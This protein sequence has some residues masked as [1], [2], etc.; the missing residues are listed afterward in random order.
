MYA[1]SVLWFA[2]LDRPVAIYVVYNIYD[3][4][5]RKMKG[6]ACE[7]SPIKPGGHKRCALLQVQKTHDWSELLCRVHKR[8]CQGLGAI[9]MHS[10]A[11]AS[12]ASAARFDRPAR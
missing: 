9:E 7:T 2:F 10:R 4:I 11:R 3:I 12:G 6:V 8:G 1:H 5:Q